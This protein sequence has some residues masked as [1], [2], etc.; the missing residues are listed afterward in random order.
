MG[1]AHLPSRVWTDSRGGCPA[2]SQVSA[3]WCPARQWSP[4]PPLTQHQPRSHPG[5]RP[6]LG[7]KGGKKKEFAL[8]G[9][10]T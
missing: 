7:K 3:T 4:V 6:G 5:R 10:C 2:D 1:Y 8:V 9:K